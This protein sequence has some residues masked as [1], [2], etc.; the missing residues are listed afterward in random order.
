MAGKPQEHAERDQH[1][2]SV[3]GGDHGDLGI[4]EPARHGVVPEAQIGAGIL[5]LEI[6]EVQRLCIVEKIRKPASDGE[7]QVFPSFFL[8]HVQGCQRLPQA[9]DPGKEH[10]DRVQDEFGDLLAGY[11]F[12]KAFDIF[13]DPHK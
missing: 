4:A 13:F 7:T 6:F 9:V 12:K 8:Q 10:R 2:F 1:R 11:I 5:T 3:P